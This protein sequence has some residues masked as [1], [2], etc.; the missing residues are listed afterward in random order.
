M[1]RLPIM[2]VA[3]L[4]DTGQMVKIIVATA[5]TTSITPYQNGVR[6]RNLYSTKQPMMIPVSVPAFA[7][8]SVPSSTT[9]TSG[10]YAPRHIG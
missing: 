6:Q 4:T 8:F 7:I 1:L 5:T 9:S 3:E 10:V 2:S